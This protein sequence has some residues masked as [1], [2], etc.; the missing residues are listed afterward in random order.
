MALVIDLAPEQERR[1][2]QEAQKEGISTTELVQRTLA[3]RFPVLSDE[4]A[5][6]LA[7]IEQWIAEAPTDSQQKREAEADLHEFQ[8]AINQTRQEAGARILYPDVK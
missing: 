6:A 2:H 1:L 4:D 8:V 7:L 3:E 5:K